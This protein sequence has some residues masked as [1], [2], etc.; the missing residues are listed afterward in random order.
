[1][2]ISN[3]SLVNYRNFPNAHL[4]FRSGVNTVIGENGSGKTNL[5]RAIRLLLDD[6]MLTAAY[7]LNEDDFHRGLADWRGHWIIISIEFADI[8]A[9]EA[10]QALFIHGTGILEKNPV[11]RATYNLI[12]RPRK[13]IRLKLAKLAD[14]DRAGMMDVLST[15]TSD[16][17]ETIFTGRSTADFN[18]V[19]FYN[20]VVGDFE[21]V[22]FA[23]VAEVPELGSIL[24]KQL[25][26][27]KEISFTFVQALRDVIADFKNNRANPLRTLLRYKSGDVDPVAFATITGKVRELNKSIEKWPD[28]GEIS[29]DIKRTMGD[30][31]GEAYSPSSLTIKSDL[32]DDA[33]QLFQSLKLFVGEDGESH[34]G[35]IHELSLGGA[36][37]IYLTLKLLEFKYQKANLSAANFLLIEEPEAHIHTHI[38]KTLFDRLDYDDTQIIYSTH[39]TQISEVSNVESMNILGREAGRSEAYQPANGLDSQ[40]VRNIQRYLD[41]VRSNLLFARSV[42]LVEGDAEEILIPTLVKK[43]L[44]VGLDELGISLINVRSTG[45]EN[46]ATLFHDDRI[47]KRCG[48]ITD[49]DAAI[50]PTDPVAEDDKSTRIFRR[51]EKG[52]QTSGAARKVLLDDFTTGNPWV[53]TFYAPHTFEVDFIAAGNS[54]AVASIV[55]DVYVDPPTITKATT[56][57]QSVSISTYGRRILTMANQ[58]GKGWFA[59]LLASK[60]N[61]KTA[62]PTYILEA[63]KFAHPTVSSEIWFNILQYRLKWIESAKSQPVSLLVD[64]RKKLDK[65][66]LGTLSFDQIKRATLTAFPDDRI[67]DILE[68]F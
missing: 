26:V 51:K 11:G 4:K 56:E 49:L 33:D 53:S 5:F 68:I 37:L 22:K 32:P 12:F 66:R 7:R 16:D 39:S 43:I 63:L 27:S 3:L 8:S 36:N 55:G 6:N 59:I 64:Y 65:F 48:I 58:E 21:N 44:G 34:E 50:L 10:I 40:K 13:E 46:V 61:H 52:S 19:D 42:L 17:Y 2:Y 25:S 62:I 15:I 28:V 23:D 54:S 14:G 24:P 31:V 45:F 29:D 1:M 57:L 9:D 47:R 18:N 67:N 41:A 35:G 60:V 20:S 38:Q 30:T